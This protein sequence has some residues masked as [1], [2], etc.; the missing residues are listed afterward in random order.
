MAKENL[1]DFQV[2]QEIERLL[3]SEDV[4]LA[5]K[6]QQILYKRR[7]YLYNLRN[8][9]KRGKKLAEQGITLDNMEAELFGEGAE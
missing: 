5:K 2:E 9:E 3:K 7:Q 8:L 4:K 6:E 1:T